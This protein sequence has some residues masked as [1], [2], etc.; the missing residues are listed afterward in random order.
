MAIAIR[1][2]DETDLLAD[3]IDLD[4]VE[5]PE[6]KD[7]TYLRNGV[8]EVYAVHGGIVKLYKTTGILDYEEGGFA[9]FGKDE[10]IE[11]VDEVP[12]DVEAFDLAPVG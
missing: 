8:G 7:G 9:L 12:A 5:K 2:D 3:R 6:L 1:I 4:G 10:D 11:I